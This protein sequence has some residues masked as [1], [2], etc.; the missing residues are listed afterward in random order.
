MLGTLDELAVLVLSKGLSNGLS[1]ETVTQPESS[2]HLSKETNQLLN[3][4]LNQTSQGPDTHPLKQLSKDAILSKHSTNQLTKL[5]SI[6]SLLNYKDAPASRVIR[7]ISSLDT[8]CDLSSIDEKYY[9]SISSDTTFGAETPSANATKVDTN[10]PQTPYY[11][12]PFPESSSLLHTYPSRSPLTSSQPKQI[13]SR[14]NIPK[15]PLSAFNRIEDVLGCVMFTCTVE[16]CNASK[17][18]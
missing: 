14:P 16:G 10:L 13:N 7:R 18:N 11:T 3:D 2:N 9:P 12:S 5:P 15:M 17:W 4:P 1:K 8:L 6:Q